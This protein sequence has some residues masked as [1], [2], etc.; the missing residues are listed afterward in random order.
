MGPLAAVHAPKGRASWWLRYEPDD[1]VTH[2]D[3][4]AGPPN[5][6][7]MAPVRHPASGALSRHV[8]VQAFSTKMNDLLRVESGLEFEL[9]QY[10]DRQRSVA[11]ITPQPV[12]LE[13]ENGRR[14]TPDLMSV[15]RDGGI[16]VWDARSVE[17]QQADFL[18]VAEATETAVRELGW[19]Y[20]IFA[21][22]SQVAS[23]NLRWLSS[24]SRAPEWSDRTKPLIVEAVGGGSTLGRL[25]ALDDG[26][27][28]LTA[29]MWH[30]AWS[31]E[32]QLDLE[33]RWN[34]ETPV[35]MG[36]PIL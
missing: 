7:D 21:G 15:S 4:T 19:S 35:R 34:E 32:L 8:P 25:I 3:L 29:V 36:E 1:P 30:M 10:L 26:A 5:P 18:V 13:W 20:E 17:R 2:W 14:H 23:L 28:H 12:R 6:L 27:G 22:L 31:G 33:Q 16:T 24:S 9:V 11:C